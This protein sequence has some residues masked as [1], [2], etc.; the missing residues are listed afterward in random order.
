[1]VDRVICGLENNKNMHVTGSIL[2]ETSA[3]AQGIMQLFWGGKL[4]LAA[5][6][7]RDER[8]CSMLEPMR[9]VTMHSHQ[10]VY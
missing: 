8:L 1:M 6:L 9:R 4:K 10:M 5:L 2:W 7:L 3:V